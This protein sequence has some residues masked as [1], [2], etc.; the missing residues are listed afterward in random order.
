MADSKARPSF[1]L[2]TLRTVLIGI[3]AFTAAMCIAYGTVRYLTRSLSP[4]GI[5]EGAQEN[6]PARRI[7]EY[8]AR[9]RTLADAFTERIPLESEGYSPEAKRWVESVFRPGVAKLR[10]ELTAQELNAPELR[11]LQAVRKL[12]AAAEQALFLAAHPEDKTLRKQTIKMMRV[13]D[14]KAWEMMN[15]GGG[16]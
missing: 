16:M 9:L 10:A 11:A 4:P 5:L 6:A 15:E 3:A 2:R 8:G 1:L 14:Q 12:R 7:A 13:A